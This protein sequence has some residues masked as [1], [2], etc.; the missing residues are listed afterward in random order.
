MFFGFFGQRH[1]SDGRALR[2]VIAGRHTAVN[3]LEV[4][5]SSPTGANPPISRKKKSVYVVVFK[6]KNR[7]GKSLH[8]AQLRLVSSSPPLDEK[9][10]IESYVLVVRRY[11]NTRSHSEHGSET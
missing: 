8:Y 10:K 3:T 1:S 4:V 6:Q 2:A 11:G 9:K 7:V 5:G